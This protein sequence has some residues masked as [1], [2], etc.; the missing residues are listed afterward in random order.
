[1]SKS[2]PGSKRRT[3]KTTHSPHAKVEQPATTEAICKRERFIRQITELSPAVLNI[4]DLVTERHT[5]FS[6]NSVNLF[7]Y[8]PDE[9]AQMKNHYAVLVHP[10]DVPRVRDNI[11]RLKRLEDGETVEFECRVQRR[12]GEWRWIAARSMI[13][14][15]DEHGEPQ[16]IINATLD[17]T[18]HKRLENA[19]RASEE[20]FR[21]YFELGLVGMAITS[22]SKGIIDVNEQICE[23]L[24]YERSELLQM[25]WAELTHPDDL[26][27]DVAN[28]NRVMAGE[29]DGYSLDKRWVRKDGNVIYATISVKCLRRPDSS[30]DSFVAL[31]Q[32]ITARKRAE[33]VLTQ[34]EA[35]FRTL[36]ENSSDVIS[37]L[38]TD[39]TILYVSPS[40]ITI[41]GYQPDELIGKN[42][43]EFVHLEDLPQMLEGVSRTLEQGD[44]TMPILSCRCRHKNGS[45]RVL[46]GGGKTWVDESGERVGVFNSRD[47]TERRRTEEF[48]VHTA[49]AAKRDQELKST[50]LDALAHEIK[51]PLAAT[52]MAVTTLLAVRGE[53]TAEQRRELLG[54]IDRNTDR[55][56]DWSSEAIR[57]ASIEAGTKSLTKERRSFAE[58]IHRIVVEL[59]LEFE[60]HRL[61]SNWIRRVRWKLMSR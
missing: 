52:K 57:A 12:D 61:T 29:I 41:L 37:V 4:F 34:S 2:A 8:T 56:N 7:G 20:R 31:V 54:V 17:I 55:L 39:G 26:A 48:L 19:L 30:V 46:E 33:E 25:T 60:T 43:F 50:F 42:A 5:H 45:W 53:M 16:Q 51:T 27:A 23:I 35:R 3:S 14:G 58:T 44:K 28:F 24:G 22:P 13:F 40:V 36:I 21:R 9:I 59:C 32:D 18:E 10:E 15:R 49:E 6:S 47:V 11:A 1:M 38:R